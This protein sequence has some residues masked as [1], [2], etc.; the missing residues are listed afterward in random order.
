MTKKEFIDGLRK[1]GMSEKAIIEHIDI[2]YDLKKDE[3]DYDL[4]ELFDIAKES[5]A[6]AERT[7]GTVTLDGDKHI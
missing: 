6:Y 5:H 2:Y 1:I 3:P 4:A 7:K